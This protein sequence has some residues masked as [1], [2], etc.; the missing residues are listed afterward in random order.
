[1]A[2]LVGH[3]G[4]C[5]GIRHI[6]DFGFHRTPTIRSNSGVIVNQGNDRASLEALISQTRQNKTEGMLIEV[7]LTNSQCR[8]MPDLVEDLFDLGFTVVNRFKNPNS[9]NICN[10]FHYNKSPRSLTSRLPYRLP[11]SKRKNQND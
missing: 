10:V 7:V 1:M 8:A 11:S 4:G 9:R 3:G 5:C 6:R 2:R